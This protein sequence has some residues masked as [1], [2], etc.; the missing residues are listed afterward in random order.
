LSAANDQVS[1]PDEAADLVF[2]LR[3]SEDV[4]LSIPSDALASVREI[5]EERD[6]S[7]EAL[8]KLYIGQG[9]RHDI[10]RRFSERSG[11]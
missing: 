11:D 9:L 2:R 3:P 6:M 4:V 10:A 5:A 7:P 1:D 8:L